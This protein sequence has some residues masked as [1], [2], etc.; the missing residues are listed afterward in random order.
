MAEITPIPEYTDWLASSIRR[1]EALAKSIVAHR[2]EK[3]RIVEG[4][5]KSALRAILP[6]RFS[7]GTGFAITS[8]GKTSPQL[9]VIIYDAWFNAPIILEGQTGLFPIECIYGFIEVKSVLNGDA[10]RTATDAIRTVRSLAS[11]K[12]YVRYEARDIGGGRAVSKEI[13]VFHG[14]APRS[15]VF[16]IRSEYASAEAIEA[17]LDPTN[18]HIHGLAVL[19]NDWFIHQLPWAEP[20][21]PNFV[22]KQGKAFALFC[23][24]VLHSIQSMQM[25]PASMRQYLKIE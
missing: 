7:I 12:Q 5:V 23:S 14:L 25:M 6:G 22:I 16:A 4:I 10:I 17:Q 21:S 24:M 20:P 18:A 9:D 1:Y 8:S 19:E 15:F 2:P 3:G 13:D 11:E